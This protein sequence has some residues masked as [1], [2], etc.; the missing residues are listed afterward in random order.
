MSGQPCKDSAGVGAKMADASERIPPRTEAALYRRPKGG[1]AG[2]LRTAAG[3]GG[4][5]YKNP[6]TCLH[7]RRISRLAGP[8]GPTVATL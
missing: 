8:Q 4:A 1:G 7:A 6:V 5:V 2:G 3:E